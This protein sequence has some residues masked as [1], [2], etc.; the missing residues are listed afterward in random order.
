MMATQVDR[1]LR[2]LCASLHAEHTN[3]LGAQ[4]QVR[5]DPELTAQCGE[6]VVFNI[7][8]PDKAGQSVQWALTKDGYGA[9]FNFG[10]TRLDAMG[11]GQCHGRLSTPGFIQCRVTCG[12]EVKLAGAGVAVYA[13]TPSLPP[14]DDFDAFW[15]SKKRLLA[16]TPMNARYN[17]VECKLQRPGVD[18]FDVQADSCVGAGVS[19][20]MSR[21]AAALPR[22]LPA[23][24]IV[25]GAGVYSSSLE[26]SQ[27]WARGG[28]PGLESGNQVGRHVGDPPHG[29]GNFSQSAL[30]MDMNAHG[31]PNLQGESY[32][33]AL[34]ASGG[35]LFEYTKR[36]RADRESCY[37]LGMLLRLVRAIDI[38]CA[39]RA[40]AAPPPLSSI[41]CL[42]YS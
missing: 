37:F 36:G 31:I 3:G 10:T 33:A 26:S 42:V 6:R 32:Y 16:A 18:S 22:S 5:S 39:Q 28:G 21:P 4:L 19:A 8:C 13:I 29:M 27:D 17:P 40:C 9:P 11:R 7:I 20:F 25:H 41:A 38:L 15:A 23:I 34:S 1:R 12:G 35:A 24:L 2:A 30:A 14:P